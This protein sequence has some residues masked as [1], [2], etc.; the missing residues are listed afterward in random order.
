MFMEALREMNKRKEETMRLFRIGLAVLLGFAMTCGYHLK[1]AVA[2]TKVPV[3]IL[4]NWIGTIPKD[5]EVMVE[6]LQSSATPRESRSLLAGGLSYMLRKIDIVPDFL[7]GVGVVDD[8]LVIR[9]AAASAVELGSGKLDSYIEGELFGLGQSLDSLRDYLGDAY[10]GFEAYVKELLKGEVGAC[11]ADNIIDD[12]ETYQQFLGEVKDAI[13]K[14]NPR[15]ITYEKRQVKA[16]FDYIVDETKG[17]DGDPSG[18][19]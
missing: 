18:R 7:E 12:E 14:Y 9:V 8:T 15:P 3:K 13:A 17:E 5:V 2:E 11:M 19:E 1:P 16:L 4:N 10:P 6:A